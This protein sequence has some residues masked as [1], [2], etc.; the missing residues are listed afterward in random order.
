MSKA[1][2]ELPAWHPPSIISRNWFLDQNVELSFKQNHL[3][4][5]ISQGLQFARRHVSTPSGS[6]CQQSESRAEKKGE[7]CDCFDTSERSLVSLHF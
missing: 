2:S 5:K 1:Y 6:Q 4:F 7:K 3:K